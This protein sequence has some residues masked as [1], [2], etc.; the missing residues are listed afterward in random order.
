MIYEL[1]EATIKDS[2]ELI[3]ELGPGDNFSPLNTAASKSDR[4]VIAMDPFNEPESSYRVGTVTVD[5]PKEVFQSFAAFF[6]VDPAKIDS[7]RITQADRLQAFA[8]VPTNIEEFLRLGIGIAKEVVIVPN[9]LTSE[10]YQPQ[11]A[12]KDLPQNWEASLLKLTKTQ[13]SDLFGTSSSK[14]LDLVGKDTKLPVI[15]ARLKKYKL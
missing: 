2:R 4:T 15:V 11:D 14:Y 9:P 6:S 10:A 12:I 1:A 8:P 7:E 13:I 3:I 5:V